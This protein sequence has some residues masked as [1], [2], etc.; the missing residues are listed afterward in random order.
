MWLQCVSTCVCTY[1]QYVSVYLCMCVRVVCVILLYSIF[2][3]M[4]V[5]VLQ[6]PLF[7]LI[8]MLTTSFTSIV[9]TVAAIVMS[10]YVDRL[11][12]VV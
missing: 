3:V 4:H 1:V 12:L 2:T 5:V 7:K 8:C 6:K 11:T 9:V 10:Q